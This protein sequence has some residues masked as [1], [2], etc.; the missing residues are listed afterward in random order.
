MDQISNVDWIWWRIEQCI[1][2]V[3]LFAT[4]NMIGR[5]SQGVRR[6]LSVRRCS[7]IKLEPIANAFGMSVAELMLSPGVETEWYR[8]AKV[9]YF[10]ANLTALCTELDASRNDL[11][12]A[13]GLKRDSVALWFNGNC[14]PRTDSVQKIADYFEMEVADLFLPPEGGV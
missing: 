1:D 13:S 7:L 11:A 4:A 12:K 14:L 6:L 10:M 9:E 8:E 3:G 5:S 2:D